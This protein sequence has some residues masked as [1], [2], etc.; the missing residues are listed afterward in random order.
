VDLAKLREFKDDVV[1][2]L[3]GGIAMLEKGNGVEVLAGSARFLDPGAVVVEGAD[4]PRRVEASAFVLA[5][6]ARP[7]EL[8]G[9]EFDGRDVWSAR[10]A[11]D[12][13]QVPGRLA[14]IG[15]GA[16]GLELGTVYAKLGS[17]V[18][19]IEALPD[20]LAGIDPE[21]VKL[22]HR[23]LR[24][25]DVAVH[26]SARAA[27]LERSGGELRLRV[28]LAGREEVVPCDKVLVAAG[29]RPNS[30][31][32]GLD[33]AGVQVGP[34]GFVT[35]DERLRTN[36]PSI[37][38]IG[39]LAGPPLLAHKASK[40]AELA[41]EAI[42]G[43][44]TERD[45]VAMPA[46]IFTDP[47]VA[48]VGLSEHEARQQGLDPVVGK[49]AFAALGRAVAIGRTEGFVKVVADRASRRLLGATIAGPEASSLI[50][51]AAL[52]LEVEAR[53]EDLAGTVHAHPT[54]PEALMEASKAAL[55]VAI[56]ALNRSDR[57]R[58]P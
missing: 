6:G 35:V 4:G 32:L 50:A 21:A 25:R 29:F 31:G 33:R 17:K 8:P 56:H 52:A 24:Q 19:V 1:K 51:E 2:K 13:P 34:G 28:Q 36:V 47:E 30:E 20:I 41:A 49:F 40:E 15:G 42:A 48:T 11:V 3:A 26:L 58:A 27:G 12:L 53:L 16:I 14:V 10:E 38:C 37:W 9:L 54:L 55:G 44:R 46:A 18:T 5:A 39:D 23:G 57:P 22:V 45:W 7:I 43:L